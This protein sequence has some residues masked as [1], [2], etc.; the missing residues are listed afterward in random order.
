VPDEPSRPPARI[1]NAAGYLTRLGN[2][3]MDPPVLRAM[4]AAS[5]SFVELDKAQLAS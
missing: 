4:E 2:S 3:I 5:R 1:I